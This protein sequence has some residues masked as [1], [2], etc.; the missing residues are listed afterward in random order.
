MGANGNANN[1]IGNIYAGVEVIADSGERNS[2]G[3]IMWLCRCLTCDNEITKAR[4]FDLVRGDYQS[5]G[6]LKSKLMSTAISRHGMASSIEYNTWSGMKDRCYNPNL[7]SYV[8][9]GGRGIDISE[10]WLN[11]FETFYED[12][13]PR[14]S[15]DHSIDRIDNNKGYSKENCRWATRSEQAYNQ[16]KRSNSSS[17]YKNVYYNSKSDRWM[18][19]VWVDKKRIYLGSFREES[20]AGKAVEDFYAN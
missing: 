5:C 2:S 9:Y 12:M 19:R 6:C 3:D 16:N 7:E 11:S 4:K 17:I 8:R 1:L 20:H 14:P 15:E 10:E 18:A 13:G